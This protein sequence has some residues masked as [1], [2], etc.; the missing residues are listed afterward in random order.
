MPKRD[1]TPPGAPCWIDLMTSDPAA[2]KAFYGELFGWTSEDSGPEYGGYISFRKDDALVAG[3]M[4]NDPAQGVPDGWSVY[5]ATDDAEATSEAVTATGGTVVV[6]TMA[7][8]ELGK[9]LVVVDP[10][11][12]TIGAWQPGTH[13][14]F[15]LV[16]EP[17]APAWF[18]LHTRDH[19]AAIAFYE[20]AFGWETE[21]AS[22]TD[23]FR[24]T[25]LGKGDDQAAGVM[26]AANFLPEGVPSLWTVYFRTADADADVAKAVA[27]GAT[28]VEPTE[29]TPYG[30]LAGLKDPTGAYFKLVG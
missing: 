7:V 4:A 13:T 14:G 29:D 1:A 23:D 28:V 15:G 5:L 18:E 2:S 26:D 20:K 3:A 25:T 9:M 6:P 17:G 19:G 22:D 8:G 10:S 12:A 30:R 11:G 21:V 27:L 16:D 24:Y